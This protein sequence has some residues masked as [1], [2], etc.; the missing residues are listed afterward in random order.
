MIDAVERWQTVCP[1]EDLVNGTGGRNQ[2]FA[3]AA[4]NALKNN[5]AAAE[6]FPVI[7]AAGTDGTDG[8]TPAAGAVIDQAVLQSVREK[9]ISPRKFLDENDSFTFFQQ[10]GGHVITGPTQTNVMDVVITLIP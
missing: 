4:L 8:P 7:L 10:V 9:K 6:K 2:E 3:L 5:H 1:V